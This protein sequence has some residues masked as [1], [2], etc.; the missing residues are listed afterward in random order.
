MEK[1]RKII[2]FENLSPEL[3]EAMRKRYPSGFHG[4]TQRIDTPKETL[5]VVSFETDD[6]I[7]MVKVK[8]TDKKSK[9]VDEEDEEF[10]GDDEFSVPDSSAS[11]GFE[12][13]KEEFGDEDEDDDY[14][15]KP[16][17]DGNEEDEDED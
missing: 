13:E 3:Q 15:D 6:S 1:K 17:E 14:G 10:F 12:K 4:H 8:L 7:Y 11:G 2:S 9:A 16:D 5:T